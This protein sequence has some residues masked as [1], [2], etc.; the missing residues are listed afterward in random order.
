VGRRAFTGAITQLGVSSIPGCYF[1]GPP[2]AERSAAVQ[3]PAL[4][5]KDRVTAVVHVPGQDDE[6]VEWPKVASAQPIEPI[7]VAEP[8]RVREMPAD[9]VD[10][11]LGSLF[12]TRSGDKAG[13]ANVGVWARDD[14]SYAW[15]LGYLTAERFHALVPEAA[16]FRTD[17]HEI[18]GVRG[19]N[20]VIHGFL[21]QGTA[22]STLVDSQAKGLGEYV[23]SRTIQV[24][25]TLL[26]QSPEQEPEVAMTGTPEIEQVSVVTG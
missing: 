6:V 24:P 19:I 8:V 14:E 10:V 7:E 11:A 1:V 16:D 5:D 13:L 15:L 22:S 9:L 26:P 3:W 21:E 2:Q 12:G 20:F 18:P 23:G 25:S 4:V 17:R